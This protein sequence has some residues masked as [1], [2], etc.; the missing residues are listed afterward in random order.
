MWQ[1]R[2][3]LTEH[4][5]TARGTAP[6]FATALMWPA[7]PAGLRRLLDRRAAPLV[8]LGLILAFSLA[9]R[10]YQIDQ[11]CYRPCAGPESR[12]I[13][14]EFYYV[15]AARSIAGIPQP[16]GSPYVKLTHV[17]FV[18]NL[19][20]P[21][22]GDDPNS[23]HPQ[24]AKVLIAGGIKLF[25]DNP[26]GWRIGS[27]LFSLIAMIALY[28]LV[29]GVGGSSWLAVG[30]V[31][32]MA[33][34]NLALVQGRIGMLDIY[35]L[36]MMLV[37][38]A[39]YVRRHPLLAGIALGVGA[40]MKE[41]AFYLL[42]ALVLFEAVRLL[43]ARLSARSDAHVD[44]LGGQTPIVVVT[45]LVECVLCSFAVFFG[46]LWLLDVLVP[47]YDFSTHTVYAGD[48][49]KHFAHIIRSAA[50]LKVNPRHPF[51]IAS[52]PLHWLINQKPIIYAG[53]EV[54][55]VGSGG[56]ISRHTRGTLVVQFVAKMNPF[57]IFALAPALALALI[58]AWR[59]RDRVA[60]LGAAWAVGVFMPYLLQSVFVDRLSYI[61]YML[62]VLPGIYM[63]AA[64]LFSWRYTPRLVTAIWA[65]LLV[66]GFVQLYPLRTVL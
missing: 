65:G 4:E 12:L 53:K 54:G 47:A 37:A 1:D 5:P 45:E 32:V 9:A 2:R 43:Q 29:T 26:W 35:A 48:P 61:W 55:T 20:N 64:Q 44:L 25:G 21:P 7:P 63:M 6:R 60:L 46:L 19:A 57:I 11:P 28:A 10:V 15:N 41:V 8:A 23:E 39:L 3:V 14:D 16:P 40:C 30:T 17:G 49:F 62:I 13:F 27:V 31:A 66:L 59:D 22:S 51:R 18:V 38:G 42:V 36:A 33:L 52:P 24:L 50:A 34:D 58:R 56:V